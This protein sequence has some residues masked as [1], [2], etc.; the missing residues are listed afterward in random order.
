MLQF[1]FLTP[2]PMKEKLPVFLR[3]RCEQSRWM[4]MKMMEERTSQM[5]PGW[6][7]SRK[8]GQFQSGDPFVLMTRWWA[9]PLW[10]EHLHPGSHQRALTARITSKGQSLKK[11][12]CLKQI[13]PS[14]PSSVDS[15]HVLHRSAARMLPAGEENASTASAASLITHHRPWYLKGWLRKWRERISLFIRAQIDVCHPTCSPT[16]S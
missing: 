3:T 12:F 2:T 8:P 15:Y 11:N 4:G 7:K 5:C 10:A 9:P 16:K 13:Q 14:F 1:F 6:Q